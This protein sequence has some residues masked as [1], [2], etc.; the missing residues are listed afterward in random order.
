MTL[1]P[2]MIT[3]KEKYEILKSTELVFFKCI[4]CGNTFKRQKK[5]ADAVIKG[6]RSNINFCSV[7]CTRESKKSSI[8]L[9]CQQCNKQFTKRPSDFKKTKNHF[10]CQSCA[11]IYSNTHKITGN[12]RSK[13]EKWIEKQLLLILPDLHID[14]NKKDAIN[15]E[16]DIYIPS[17]KLAFE[18]NGIFHYEPIYGGNKLKS[19]K[20]NDTRK[21][22]ACLE[23]GIELCIIDISHQKYFKTNTSKVFLDI[24]VNIIKTK[25]VGPEG[26]EPP[27]KRL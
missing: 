17:L 10:C 2:N 1:L 8:T 14:Y 20:T 27:T 15:S 24:I 13:L 7:H 22:Q 6:K 9:S 18:L 26:F 25:L 23:Q 5:E 21:F 16:L 11:A 19:I 12:R 4:L 3:T